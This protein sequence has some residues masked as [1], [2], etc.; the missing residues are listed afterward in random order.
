MATVM[1]G[2]GYERMHAPAGHCLLHADGARTQ[3]SGSSHACDGDHITY[4]MAITDPWHDVAYT[5]QSC[6]TKTTQ[7]EDRP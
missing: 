3:S 2:M 5:H 7:Q 4:V 1:I 6:W